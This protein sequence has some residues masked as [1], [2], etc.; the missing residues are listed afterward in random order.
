VIAVLALPMR[1]STNL[2]A[3]EKTFDVV[4]TNTRIVDGT[5]NP[6][7]RAAVGIKNGIITRIGRVDLNEATKV[8]DAKD[9]IVAPGFID[10]H[11]HVEGIYNNP[12]ADNFV[13]MGVTSLVTGN[14]GGSSV[15][16]GKFLDRIKETPLAVNLATLIGHNSVRSQVMG[17]ENREPTK[18]EQQKM[19]ALVEQA[20]KDGAVGLS[21]GLIYVPGTYAKTDEVVGLARVASR[22]GGIYATHMRNEG[23]E[24]VAAIN[25]SIKIGEEAKIP[26]EISHFKIS[27][28]R[29]WG[30]NQTTLNLVREARK[31]GLQVTVDQYVYTAS[32]TSLDTLLPNWALAG[33]RE[34][35]KK[36]LADP[37]TKERIIKEMKDLLKESKFKDYSYAVVANYQT[38]KDFNGKS[39]KQLAKQVRG[40]DKLDEQIEQIF[41]MYSAG[42]AQ[43][44][45][46]KMN[47][48]DVKAFLKEPF[49]MIAADSGVRRIGEGIP[50]PR[51]Y[52]NNARVLGRYVRELKLITLEDAIRKMTSLPA[53][54]FNLRNRGLLREGYAADLVIFDEKTIADKATFENPHQYAEGISF[55]FV[56]GE[57][58]FA[59]GQMTGTRSGKSL[60]GIEAQN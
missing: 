55:V 18:E 19:E 54:T 53:Q 3:T 23:E 27:S 39:I 17:T 11:A 32:S 20:M 15:E 49:T 6:W 4:I 40:K 24:V 13:R 16:V 29:L 26:V 42:G 59:Q 36:R 47:E 41:E 5:G 57:A 34:E 46:H 21:T 14:C 9:Q 45:F 33:G 2:A 37:L 12:G 10:V 50:H 35:G 52:G 58:V 56:N 44:V 22:Y 38:N 48:D 30:K 60:R 7:F 31:K 1:H 43:M 51:G 25:E 28:K 8:I